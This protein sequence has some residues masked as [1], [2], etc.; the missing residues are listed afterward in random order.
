MKQALVGQFEKR[1][2][3]G[4]T[5]RGAIDVPAEQFSVVVLFGPSGCGKT[6]MLRCLAG[7]ERPQAGT[8]RYGSETWFEA[9]RGVFVSPQKRGVGYVFQEYALFPHMSVESNIAYGL[10]DVASDERRRRVGAMLDLFDLNGL[11]GR[12]P[13]Q[14]SGGQQQRVALARSLVRRPRLLLLDEPLSALDS[15]LREQIRSS[16]RSILSEFRIPVILVTHDR[17]EASALADQIIVMHDGRVAQTG[18]AQ[19]VFGRPATLEVARFV[20]METVVAGN[21]VHHT[22]GVAEVAINEARIVARAPS[23]IAGTVHVCIRGEDVV[24]ATPGRP[25]LFAD[26]AQRS[27]TLHGVVTALSLEGPL[28]RISLDCGFPLAAFATRPHFEALNL[29]VGSATTASIAADAIHL[30]GG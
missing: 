25:G 30:I 29:T 12:Y 7:L 2:G 1:F 28:V 22:D 9:E 14:L 17:I 8:I 27:N 19:D 4:A 13:S 6:T 11:A 21:V 23:P 18:T 10:Y 20:N 15:A 24:L 3:S 5:I 26:T 16:L